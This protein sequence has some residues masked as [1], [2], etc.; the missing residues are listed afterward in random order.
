MSDLIVHRRRGRPA[1]STPYAAE[2]TATLSQVA[3]LLWQTPGLS[4]TAAIKQI[5]GKPNDDSLIR[6][7]RKKL[8]QDWV[9][10]MREA[11]IR[12]QMATV[13]IDGHPAP[14]LGNAFIMFGELAN[15]F[16]MWWRSP[17]VQAVMAKVGDA[18][19]RLDAFLKTPEGQKLLAQLSAVAVQS[20]TKTRRRL[21]SA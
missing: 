11:Q 10:L 16:E 3:D 12:A 21:Q 6:R 5:T 15:R 18:V 9:Q 7:L 13:E 20:Q 4:R 17:K 1:G 14:T 19:V 2:D 8:N